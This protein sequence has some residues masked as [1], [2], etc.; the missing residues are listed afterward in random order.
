MHSNLTLQKC[1]GTVNYEE[2]NQ[3]EVD[4]EEVIAIIHNTEVLMIENTNN[5]AT[6][7]EIMTTESNLSDETVPDDNTA[8]LKESVKCNLCASEFDDKEILKLHLTEKHVECNQCDKT[9]PC[10]DE[11]IHSYWQD[12][13]KNGYLKASG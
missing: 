1:G 2:K 3:H 6:I 8:P 7:E 10:L 5:E 12:E 13:V 4:S 9:F 11:M